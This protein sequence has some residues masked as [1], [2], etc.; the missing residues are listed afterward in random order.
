MDGGTGTGL[1]TMLVSEDV[2]LGWVSPGIILEPGTG[3]CEDPGDAWSGGSDA[4]KSGDDGD[5]SDDNNGD[6]LGMALSKGKGEAA[7]W[8]VVKRNPDKGYGK[9]K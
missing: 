5:G 7:V 2:D 6:A 9:P 4:G 3:V 8:K 1:K